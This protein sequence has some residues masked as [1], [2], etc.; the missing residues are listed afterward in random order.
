MDQPVLLPG[1]LFP[2]K[3]KKI[4]SPHHQD[5]HSCC[6]GCPECIPCLWKVAHQSSQKYTFKAILE[7]RHTLSGTSPPDRLHT[8]GKP[9]FFP[10]LGEGGHL[11]A[12]LARPWRL[13]EEPRDPKAGP[14]SQAPQGPGR[15]RGGNRS[16]RRGRAERPQGKGRSTSFLPARRAEGERKARDGR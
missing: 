12:Q 13:Q 5:D 7:R 4:H 11:C 2:K 6:L 14:A 1:S 10:P 3:K 16:P 9:I 15:S 8:K